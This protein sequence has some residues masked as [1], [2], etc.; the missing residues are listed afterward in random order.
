MKEE[1][2]LRSLVVGVY[3]LYESY[4]IVRFGMVVEMKGGETMK[5]SADDWLTVDLSAGRPP[6]P[7]SLT[8]ASKEWAERDI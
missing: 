8:Q 2:N 3:Q 4:L 5:Q 1:T 6:M 7:P